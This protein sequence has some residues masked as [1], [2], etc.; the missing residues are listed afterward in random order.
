MVIIE[1]EGI[2]SQ[3]GLF[4]DSKGIALLNTRGFVVEY[5]AKLARMAEVKGCNVS[6]LVDWDVSG[7]LI[8]LKLKRVVSGVKRIGV[9]FKTV[10]DL[11]LRVTDV[12]EK[13]TPEKR[14]LKSL[15]KELAEAIDWAR[16]EFGPGS[17]DEIE[18][19]YIK[20][21][22]YYLEE[23]R[24]EINSIVAGLN[25]NARF[26]G[27]IEEELRFTF[28]DRV[29]LRSV[30]IPSYVEPE[31]LQQLNDIIKRIG[32]AA[33]EPRKEELED[34]LSNNNIENAFLFD[35]TNEVQQLANYTISSYEQAIIEQ[36][37]KIIEGNT[38][39]KPYLERIRDIL[40]QIPKP[41]DNKSNNK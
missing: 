21:Q 14:H 12:Q 1:K 30:D 36:S 32:T 11:R 7:L 28:Q 37:R 17:A 38:N 40:D 19:T 10:E 8:Y 9:D 33:L 25:D 29:F 35:R 41:A 24:I 39:I 27:W 18:Y 22:L 31:L 6:I 20:S 26:W 23:H 16:R 4:A 3:I 5:G 13:Y 15:K 2:I 34:K